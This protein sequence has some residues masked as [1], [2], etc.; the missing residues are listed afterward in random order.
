MDI[1]NIKVGSMSRVQLHEDKWFETKF[2]AW[3][4][5]GNLLTIQ[6]LAEEAT[7]SKG[8]RFTKLI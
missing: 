5:R 8:G 2:K 7:K 3:P 1:L 4:S 6:T